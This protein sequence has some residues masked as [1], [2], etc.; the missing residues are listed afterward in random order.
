MAPIFD[1]LGGWL[2]DNYSW[3][4]VFYINIGRHRVAH[5]DEA[6]HLRPGAYPPGVAAD[7]YWGIGMLAVGIGALQFVLDKDRKTTGSSR[8]ITTLAILSAVTPSHWSFRAADGRSGGRPARVQGANLRGGRAFHDRDGFA[9]RQHRPVA[10]HAATLLGY[11]PMMAGIAMA[12]RGIGSFFM[13]P[14]T[15]LITGRFDPRF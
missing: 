8:M 7:Y 6:V 9:V 4:W 10:H 11:P 1:P 15:G 14:I 3:R 12:P 2:T 13:M 5:H